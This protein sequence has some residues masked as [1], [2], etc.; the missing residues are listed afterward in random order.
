MDTIYFIPIAVLLI[1]GAFVIGMLRNRKFDQ[2]Q[3]LHKQL[4][5]QLGLSLSYLNHRDF[6]IFGKY[7][8]Y[9]LR[10]ETVELPSSDG[11]S[12][13]TAVKCSIPMVNP[14]LKVLRIEKKEESFE[15]FNHIAAITRPISMPHNIGEWLN[16]TTND[17]MFAS[18]L[19]SDDLKISIFENLNPLKNSIVF[20]EGEELAFIGLE[21]IEDESRIELYKKGV[22]LL[23][24]IKNE[25]NP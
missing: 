18:I 2:I 23:V 21:L 6:T 25:L 12:K 4:S 13:L 5:V 8:S 16:I 19:L 10:I 3:K 20:I 14:Q 15:Y 11:S 17:M 22:E 9:Q 7:Q 1:G 24:E